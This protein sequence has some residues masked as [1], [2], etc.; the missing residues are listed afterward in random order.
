MTIDAPGYLAAARTARDLIADP[1]VST[2][3][4]R[5]SAL[6]GFT[7]GGLAAHLGSQVLMVADL[8]AADPPVAESVRALDHYARATWVG[9][10][11]D[12][13]INVAIRDRGEQL[14]G[15][16]HAALLAAVDE[17]LA[18]LES[19]L[20]AADPARPMPTPA[21]PWALPLAETLLTRTL[22][23]SVHLDDL[24]VSVDLPTPPLPED[25]LLPVL[26]LLATLA[27]RRHGQPAVLR[28]LTR[29]ERASGS[30]VAFGPQD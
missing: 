18:G 22:E 6:P 9:A 25:T 1:A 12:A 27:A 17:A 26:G 23:I 21:G 13:A 30:I 14:A 8:L 28:A 11:R 2:A 10:D 3:W 5:P 16:G 7:V 15:D 19:A 20:P 24:A 29:S 4:D